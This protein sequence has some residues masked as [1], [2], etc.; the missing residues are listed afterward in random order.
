MKKI[1]LFA[2]VLLFSAAASGGV[3][4]RIGGLSP[5]GF[6]QRLISSDQF[7]IQSARIALEKSRNEDIRRFAQKVIDYHNATT[8]KL[9]VIAKRANLAPADVSL[10]WRQR[11]LIERL[12]RT[13]ATRF[14]RY[15][16]RIQRKSHTRTAR[17]LMSYASSG[18][19]E[20]LKRLARETLPRIIEHG[21]L[22]KDVGRFRLRRSTSLRF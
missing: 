14:D 4:A 15:F 1:V 13:D 19:N 9:K 17:L 18:D 12:R 6:M 2:V 7:Q 8:E 22:M 16:V 3:H 11:R 5:Q 10:S 20:D 21:R